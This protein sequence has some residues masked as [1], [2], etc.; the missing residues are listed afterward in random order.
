VGSEVAIAGHSIDGGEGSP[1]AVVDSICNC[2]SRQRG[3][4]RSERT[5]CTCSVID[6]NAYTLRAIRNGETGRKRYVWKWNRVVPVDGEIDHVR[7]V[8][9]VASGGVSIVVD[10]HRLGRDHVVALHERA[11]V[12][13]KEAR[14][15]H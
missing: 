15:K 5:M 8:V 4:E 1:D 6:R 9:D 2:K 12:N 3:F 11:L 13:G 7:E 10:L 14:R